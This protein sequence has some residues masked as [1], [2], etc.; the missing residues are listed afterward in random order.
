[1]LTPLLVERT[2]WFTPPVLQLAMSVLIVRRKL[3]REV[4]WFL[5]FLVFDASQTVVSFF[6]RHK[7]PLYFYFYWITELMTLIIGFIII[8]EIFR[9]IVS[10]YDGIQRVGFMLYRWC[11]VL[12]LFFATI[13]VASSPDLNS[14]AIFDT[15]ITLQRGV[16]I[17]QVGLLVLLFSF[18]TYLGLSW[19]NCSF[20]VALG[21]GFLAIAELTIAALRSHIG[22]DAN[23]FYVLMKQIAYNCATLIWT[24]YVWQGQRASHAVTTVARA[25]V[26][27]WNQTLTEY[28]RR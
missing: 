7:M 13:T 27:V 18:T 24:V 10:R 25:E 12:L 19:R 17:M 21:F 20:G 15:I 6:I 28:L 26:A 5:A 11:A 23:Q 1:M 3:Y 4:P 16:R 2:L 14:A 9:N 8:Y 22:P